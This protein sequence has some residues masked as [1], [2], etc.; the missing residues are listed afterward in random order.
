MSEPRSPES[1]YA[2]FTLEDALHTEWRDVRL[3]F[4]DWDWLEA[5]HG[6]DTFDG[7]YLNGYGVQGLVKAVLLTNGIDP[8]DPDIKNYNSEGD[9][10]Y[11]HFRTMDAALRAAELSA[12]MIRDR[13]AILDMV[14]VAREHGFED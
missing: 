9:T 5:T 8:N 12:R 1:R 4:S 11:I 7:Y 14:V 3:K 6:S 13:Q 2:P 10:C